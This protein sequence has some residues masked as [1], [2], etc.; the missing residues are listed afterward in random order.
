MSRASGSSSRPSWDTSGS[1]TAKLRLKPSSNKRT[2]QFTEHL[3]SPGAGIV[4]DQGDAQA[5][6]QQV[7]FFARLA[8]AALSEHV[9]FG[10]RGELVSLIQQ[11]LAAL[12]FYIPQTGV[13]DQHTGLAVD[14]Y[15]RLLGWSFSQQA[16]PRTINALLNGQGSFH[17]RFPNDGKHVEGDLHT[18]LLALINGSQ[19]YRIYPISSGKPSTPTILGHFRVYERVPGDPRRTACTSRTSSSAG[20]RFHGYN[21]APDYIR[22]ATAVGVVPITDAISVFDWLAIGDVV[23][24]YTCKTDAGPAPEARSARCSLGLGAT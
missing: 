24:T 20:T 7:G 13:Y 17:V 9:G 18:Q 8:V 12:H 19:V 14:A 2:G 23:D 4:S 10:S 11:R 3:R 21:P 15:H 5:H 1:S 22:P 16:D 6:G